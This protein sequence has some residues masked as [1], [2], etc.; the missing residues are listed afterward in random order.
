MIDNAWEGIF[1][2][3]VVLN[4]TLKKQNLIVPQVIFDFKST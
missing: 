2:T 3:R 1:L 4:E